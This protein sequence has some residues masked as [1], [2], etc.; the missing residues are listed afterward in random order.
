MKKKV[1]NLRM[2]LTMKPSVSILKLKSTSRKV[3]FIVDSLFVNDTL[4]RSKFPKSQLGRRWKNNDRDIVFFLN[5]YFDFEKQTW[6]SSLFKIPGNA[7]V[8]SIT[9][10]YKYPILGNRS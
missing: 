9:P 6:K 3:D 7:W 8:V 5:S 10:E 1:D 2:K 4:N